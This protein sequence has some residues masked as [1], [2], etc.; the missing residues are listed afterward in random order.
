MILRMAERAVAGSSDP[1]IRGAANYRAG[2]YKA[3]IDDLE[4]AARVFPRRAWDWFF[5][6]M[7][8][9]HLGQNSEAKNCLREA[10]EAFEQAD[11]AGS[12][13]SW[14]RWTERVEVEQLMREA[15]ALVH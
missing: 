8:R 7:A 10:T 11:R 4:Q 6:A 12:T 2:C 3:A 13:V 1:R 15:R 5:L 14:F 9:H